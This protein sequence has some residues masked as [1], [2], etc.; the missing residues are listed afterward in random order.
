[1]RTVNCVWTPWVDWISR[2]WGW[3]TC[4]VASHLQSGTSQL[5][6]WCLFHAE[7]APWSSR[8]ARRWELRRR[9]SWPSWRLFRSVWSTSWRRRAST[10]GTSPKWKPSTSRRF[11]R[12][13]RNGD[14]SKP[15]NGA[16]HNVAMRATTEFAEGSTGAHPA[17]YPLFPKHIGYVSWGLNET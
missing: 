6:Y 17:R 4:P 3:E 14:C 10:R 1:M 5:I 16:A 8:K 9:W 11:S 7:S 13:S 15:I 2:M 12:G